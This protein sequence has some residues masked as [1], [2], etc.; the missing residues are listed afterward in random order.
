[1]TG[2]DGRH[3]PGASYM[4]APRILRC[5]TASWQTTGALLALSVTLIASGC[6]SSS[7]R[8]PRV[9]NNLVSSKY[10]VSA[11]PRVVHARAGRAGSLPKGGGTRKLGQPYKI[12]GRWYRPK[13][14]PGY[15]RV[16]IASWYGQ[17][18]HGRLTANGE[19]YDMNALTAA[20][21]TLPLPSYGYVT[22]L[23][24]NRTVLVRIN[25]RGPFAGNR[26]IDL[27][28]A[29]AKALG[30][31]HAG[32]GKV[33]VQYAGPAPLDGNDYHEKQFLAAQS[34]ARPQSFATRRPRVHQSRQRYANHQTRPSYQG[35]G[36]DLHRYRNGLGRY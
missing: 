5:V 15:D 28:R 7:D 6:S 11:S 20:H 1:M 18:F 24:N 31:E 22:N 17:D 32:V 27:S 35:E 33:R 9:T 30:L 34:W 4:L 10:G 12:A 14:D 25:D 36:W 2:Q 21:K 13:E 26:I 3:Q 8:A 23:A 16:G 29:T 19:T